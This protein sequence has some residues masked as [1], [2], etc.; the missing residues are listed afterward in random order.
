MFRHVLGIRYL[1]RKRLKVELEGLFGV[2][3]FAVSVS[4]SYIY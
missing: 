2:G 4:P 1:D 3:N